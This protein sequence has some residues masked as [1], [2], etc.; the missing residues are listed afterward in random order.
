MTDREPPHGRSVDD[1]DAGL[2]DPA[3][4]SVREVPQ[5]LCVAREHIHGVPRRD[6]PPH[7]RAA[8]G[9]R[10]ADARVVTMGKPG[11][12][13]RNLLVYSLTLEAFRNQSRAAR[14]CSTFSSARLAGG[15]RKAGSAIQRPRS[16]GAAVVFRSCFK[17]SATSRLRATAPRASRWLG[18]TN[19]DDGSPEPRAP[20]ETEIVPTC[21]YPGCPRTTIAVFR[22]SRFFEREPRHPREHVVVSTN[23]RAET[24]PCPRRSAGV[25]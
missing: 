18:S 1:R 21:S 4:L 10:A 22:P 25:G 3:P 9:L 12:T 2:V 24:L 14:V 20:R 15:S 16:A 5:I 6:E 17:T 13:H 11:D 19:T 23:G 8:I 7:H